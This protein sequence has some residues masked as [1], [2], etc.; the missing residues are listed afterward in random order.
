MLELWKKLDGWKTAISSIYWGLLSFVVPI[1]APDG[2]HGL[3]NKITLTIG[4]LLTI[5][6]VGHKFYKKTILP[7]ITD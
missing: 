3:P 2:L 7:T 6:G 4:A 5:A 1:W